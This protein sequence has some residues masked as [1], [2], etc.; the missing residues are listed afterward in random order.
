MNDSLALPV[1]NQDFDLFLAISHAKATPD[2]EAGLVVLS[3]KSDKI[4]G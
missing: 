3:L 1:L 2:L 4:E